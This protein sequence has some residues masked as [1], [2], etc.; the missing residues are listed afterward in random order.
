MDEKQERSLRRK[1][2]RLRLQGLRLCE[3]L[4][5]IPRGH[6]WL[7]KWQQRFA[8]FGWA[9]LK[10]QSRQPHRLATCYPARTRRLVV[11]ARLRLRKRRVGLI[12][13]RAIQDELHEAHLLRRVPSVSTIRRI[14]HEHGLLKAPR[15][16]APGYFPHPTAT[17]HYVLHAMDWTARYLAG[18]VKVFAFHTIDLHTRAMHQ[19]LSTDKTGASVRQ[20]AL[21]VWQNL[22]LPEGL[23]MDND[24]AF[25]GGY[26]APRVFGDFVRLCLYLGMEPIFLPV[27]EPKRNS[28]VE[29][30]NGL[31]S[32]AFWKRRRFRS[33]PH[34]KRASPEFAAWYARHYPPPALTGGALRPAQPPAKWRRLTAADIRALPTDLPITAGRLHFIRRVEPQGLIR[35]LNETWKVDQ[36]L[37]GQYVWATVVTHQQRLEIYH[38]RSEQD[39]V[40]LLKAF[41]YEIP[42]PLVPLL[43]RFKRPYRRRKMSTMC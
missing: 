26:K 14:L 22:G 29:R 31:W 30:L 17:E 8:Q 12:G 38:R 16:A 36:R 27:H 23:Q 37:A 35:V 9:G 18:G 43:P 19:T 41:S 7:H 10:S 5:R 34:V 28:V 4:Q 42:Q 2:I 25:C 1:A 32:Q 24:A 39:P 13:P 6:S 3:I 20:H 33:V 11:Q 21:Q 15:P 40:R